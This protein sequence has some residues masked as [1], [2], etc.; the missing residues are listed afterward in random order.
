M[1]VTDS[2]GVLR[3]WAAVG[4]TGVVR[5]VVLPCGQAD[6][7]GDGVGGPGDGD[8]GE[9]QPGDALALAGGGGGVVPD[10][11]QVGGQLADPD[12]LGVGELPGVVLAGLI[13]CVLGLGE[14]AQRGIPVGF[15]GVGD[16]P[17]SGSADR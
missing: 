13:G 1:A 14:G 9:Q 7:R 5:V 10:G 17:V 15:E 3:I 16:E 2:A 4:G 11:G 6:V 12:V 8:V